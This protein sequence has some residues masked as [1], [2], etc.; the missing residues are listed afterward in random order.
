MRLIQSFAH[1]QHMMMCGM[2]GYR[3][4]LGLVLGL[5]SSNRENIGLLKRYAWL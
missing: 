2:G 1:G 4:L 3:G 5:L